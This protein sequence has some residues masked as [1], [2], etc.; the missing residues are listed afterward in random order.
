MLGHGWSWQ[1]SLGEFPVIVVDTT[2]PVVQITSPS[3][4]AL[5]SGSNATVTA[6]VTDI[7]GVTS[8]TVNGVAA[9]RTS[10]SRA[11]RDVERDG[12]DWLPV[13]A[14]G[15]VRF[16]VTAL[17]GA[18]NSRTVSRLVDN[19]GIPS[20]APAPALAPFGLDRSRATGDDL[21]NAF[22]S[23]FNNGI[24]AGTVTRNGWTMTL[25][26]G[27]A[28]PRPPF[29]PRRLLAVDRLGTGLD[30]RRGHDGHRVRVYRG[31]EAGAARRH[32]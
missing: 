28:P 19:D 23:D 22:T 16:D 9:S 20:A 3:V 8:V 10:G 32:R 13:P 2:A 27:S 30:R 17:D 1:P 18:G 15:A 4:D 31:R 7:V 6:Q 24:T 29:G 26:P 12:S 5:L 14:G 11:S 21:S 25:A